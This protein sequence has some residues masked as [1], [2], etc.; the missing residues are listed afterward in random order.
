MTTCVRSCDMDI[1][2]HVGKSM[3]IAGIY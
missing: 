1:I 2:G 3:K